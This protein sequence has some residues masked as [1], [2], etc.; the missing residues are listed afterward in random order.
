[1]V[2]LVLG[3]SWLISEFLLLLI[4]SG[5]SDNN[6]DNVSGFMVLINMLLLLLVLFIRFVISVCL[7][8]CSISW[9]IWI[10]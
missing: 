3:W 1:M 4:N 6:G 7:L 8:D 9:L 2:S 10:D 5:V